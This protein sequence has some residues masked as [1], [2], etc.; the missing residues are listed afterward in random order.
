MIA[1]EQSDSD[2][3][4]FPADLPEVRDEP[5]W[6]LYAQRATLSVNGARIRADGPAFLEWGM[7]RYGGDDM[8][9]D[10][11]HQLAADLGFRGSPIGG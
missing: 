9:V 11:A 5:W 10:E 3:P 2:A 4:L 8:T 7:H 1:M 6:S